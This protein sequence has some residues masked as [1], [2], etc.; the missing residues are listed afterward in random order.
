FDFTAIGKDIIKR[1]YVTAGFT[2]FAIMIPL[3]ATSNAAM[4]R[5]LGKRWQQ[6]HRLVYVAAMAAVIH[7]YWLVKADISRPVQYGSVLALLLGYRIFA[8]LRQ[9]KATKRSSTRFSAT[10]RGTENR[11]GKGAIKQAS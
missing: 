4:I 1:P 3:A 7:F 10:L 6:L 9:S 11:R 8:K 5:R 2:A